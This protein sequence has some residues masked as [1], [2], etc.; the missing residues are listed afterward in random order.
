MKSGYGCLRIDKKTI[1]AHRASYHLFC[2]P[3]PDG[4]H[5]LH[6][7]DNRVCANPGH[8]FT[9]TN[10]ENIRDSM[11]KGRRTGITRRRPSGLTYNWTKKPGPKART[12]V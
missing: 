7:C 3:I 10:F 5:V 2:G 12:H 11:E 9:G 4:A 6:R 8:L 1:S